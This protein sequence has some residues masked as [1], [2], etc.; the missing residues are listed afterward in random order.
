[1]ASYNRL[2]KSNWQVVI[3]LGYD[4]AGKRTRLKK[5]GF[6]TKKEAEIFVTETLN[7]KNKGYIT[8]TTNSILLKDFI[9]EWF[10]N[11]KSNTLGINT[12]NNYLSRINYHII[13]K[14][15]NLKLTDITNITIQNFYNSLINENK[16]APASAKKIIEILN[17]CFKYAK[18]NK[19]IYNI[20]TDIEKIKLE[21]PKIDY[22]DKN[23]VDFFL[24]EIQDT[25][26]YTPVFISLLTGLRVGEL[27]GLRWSD[28]DFDNAFITVNNQVIQDKINKQLLL[29]D[30]LKTSTSHR[31]VSIP[32]VLI[33]HLKELREVDSDPMNGFIIK[34]RNNCMAN[35]RN[36]SIEFTKKVSKYKNLKQI[37]FHSLR[38]TH[39]TL[40]IF[41][42]ENIKV[43][44]DRLGHKD[45]SV[46]LNTYT[47]VMEDMQKNT[48]KLLDSLFKL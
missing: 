37:S 4:E 16:L 6:K 19:L 1:M 23:N 33:D 14:L 39:A 40:L 9:L 27:C 41:H 8:P 42:G 13:P 12:K 21:K 18:K 20:P 48:A 25:Y 45:I 31:N 17:N 34:D 32:N 24:N 10:N 22:W 30:V 46:T 11:Y 28:I 15:G 35:P 26:L 47:H 43:V 44:S 5:Q 36:V 29:S 3:S 2:S 7:K 38:H